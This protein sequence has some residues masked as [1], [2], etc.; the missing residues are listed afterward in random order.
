MKKSMSLIIVFLPLCIFVSAGFS[1]GTYDGTWE[2]T[3]ITAG[4][5]IEFDVQDDMIT[6]LQYESPY[7]CP[8][9]AHPQWSYG[10]GK[11]TPIQKASF[12]FSWGFTLEDGI[13]AGESFMTIILGRFDSPD[14]ITGFILAAC[15]VF[16]GVGL[17]TEACF[18]ADSWTAIKGPLVVAPE[19][20]ETRKEFQVR[21]D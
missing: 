10:L 8:S 17:G 11:E 5:K 3:T 2:G 13:Q 7:T 16:S 20:G 19:C 1:Q 12:V 21:I 18:F 6:Y 15:A 4:A 14:T 9:G